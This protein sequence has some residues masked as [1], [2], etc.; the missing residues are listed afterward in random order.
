MPALRRTLSS[1]G[2]MVTLK[3]WRDIDKYYEFPFDE[4]EVSHRALMT[5]VIRR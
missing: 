1:R 5:R 2:Y 4:K 3:R